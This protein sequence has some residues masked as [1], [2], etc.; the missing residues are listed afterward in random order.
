MPRKS[1]KKYSV[2]YGRP[3][4]HSRFRPGQS[5][6]PNGRAKG[7]KNLVTV[8]TKALNERVAITE[9]GKRRSIS[10]LEAAIKQLVNKAAGGDA[11]AIALLLNVVRLSD[12]RG[13]AA[14]PASPP[15]G[16]ADRRVMEQLHERLRRW[17]Q[18]GQDT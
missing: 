12:E 16:E 13:G 17:G 8:L 11:K 6:N 7:A 4:A 2:G 5:G 1:A 18:G 3:P 9:N 15:L 10:K 14:D